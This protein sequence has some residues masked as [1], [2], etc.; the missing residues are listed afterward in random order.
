MDA[1]NYFATRNITGAVYN[2]D[3]SFI[4]TLYCLLDTR[5]KDEDKLLMEC[6][7]RPN[8]IEYLKEEKGLLEIFFDINIKAFEERIAK[9]PGYVKLDVITQFYAKSF[10]VV[11]YINM[12]QKNTVLLLDGMDYSRF[13]YLQCTIAGYMPWYFCDES[14]HIVVTEQEKALLDSLRGTSKEKYEEI[15]NFFEKKYDFKSLK[16]K[17]LLTGFESR[18][19]VNRK[20]RVAQEILAINNRINDYNNRIGTELGRLHEQEV[21]LLGLEAKIAETGDSSEIM[22]YFL[23]NKHLD[24]VNVN[25]N[26]VTFIAWDYLSFFDEEM[27]DTMIEN[28]RSVFYTTSG[29]SNISP[30]D[31]RLL[32]KAVFSDGTIKIKFCA[33]YTLRIDGGVTAHSHYSYEGYNE[34]MPNTHIDSYN[35]MGNYVRYINEALQQNDYIGAIEQCIASCKSLNFSDSIVMEKFMSYLY[36]S[37]PG[38]NTRCFE[39]PDG[40][41]V[42]PAK[43]IK[44]LKGEE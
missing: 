7:S 22:E 11:C 33:A 15:V 2:G 40:K 5:I 44:F 38:V 42:T 4:T 24:L 27:F 28:D 10:N 1:R 14:G 8:S 20:N 31:M 6:I 32:L 36:S 41:V 43:A 34:C 37:R 21:I 30:E 9:F 12:E 23:C 26:E 29:Q 35:C 16:I 3:V 25:N 13:H 19:D 17:R 18:A 39:L